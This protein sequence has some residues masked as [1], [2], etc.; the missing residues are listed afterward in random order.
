MGW[1]TVAGKVIDFLK[2]IFTRKQTS[3]A[4]RDAKKIRDQALELI[5]SNLNIDCFFII[6]VH[7]GGGRFR[8]HGFKYWSIIDGECDTKVMPRYDNESYQLINAD[9]EFLQFALNLYEQRVVSVRVDEMPKG[10]LRTSYEY[11]GLEFIKFY[12]LKQD[13][14]GLWFIMVGTTAP[15]ESLDDPEQAGKIFFA[16]NNIKNLIRKY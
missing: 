12:F 4:I 8:P 13:K 9:N 6:M 11:E 16:I 5:R 10:N 1:D 7:N 15:D 14:F 3:D 2:V